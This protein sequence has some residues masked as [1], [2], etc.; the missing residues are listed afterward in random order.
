MPYESLARAIEERRRRTSKGDLK[1]KANYSRYKKGGPKGTR[2]LSKSAESMESSFKRTLM[3]LNGP[4]LSSYQKGKNGLAQAIEQAEREFGEEYASFTHIESSRNMNSDILTVWFKDNTFLMFEEHNLNSG[5]HYNFKILSAEDWSGDSNGKLAK[6]LAK[7]R[8]D[9]KKPR[10]PLKIERLKA[11]SLCSCEIPR[12]RHVGVHPTVCQYCRFIIEAES[13]SAEGGTIVVEGYHP[14]RVEPMGAVALFY[15]GDEA[16]WEFGNLN[17]RQ[18]H[19]AGTPGTIMN[20]TG[21]T[22]SDVDEVMIHRTGVPWTGEYVL[23]NYTRSGGKMVNNGQTKMYGVDADS[24]NAEYIP[25]RKDLARMG[26]ALNRKQKEDLF[27][28]MVW[29]RLDWGWDLEF[30]E[31]AP[32]YADNRNYTPIRTVVIDELFYN[33]FSNNEEM[34]NNFE[35]LL[36][37]GYFEHEYGEWD[38][39]IKNTINEHM[40]DN[41]IWDE[42][43]SEDY[44]YRESMYNRIKE[45]ESQEFNQFSAEEFHLTRPEKQLLVY[46]SK[47]NPENIKKWDHSREL[48][49]PKLAKNVLN[50]NHHAAV[51]RPLKALIDKGLIQSIMG[52]VQGNK[53]K[54]KVYYPTSKGIKLVEGLM[55]GAEEFNT[56]EI[57]AH[58]SNLTGLGHEEIHNSET[59]NARGKSHLTNDQVIEKSI[60]IMKN[61]TTWIWPQELTSRINATLPKRRQVTQVFVSRAIGKG[62]GG[63][64]PFYITHQGKIYYYGDQDRGEFIKGVI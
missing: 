34:Y 7:V 47:Y 41:Y 50:S 45:I 33:Q 42:L 39:T 51:V 58:E 35:L 46:L 43:Y 64:K 11:E 49:Q 28:D 15:I 59:F 40:I 5:A 6:S 21:I 63:Y 1:A 48:T 16:E 29:E 8:E 60:E 25:D 18:L 53:R 32:D 17:E 4:I 3:H 27:C 20:P 31:Y 36:N 14:K 52:H 57:E 2:D 13:F 38:R 10:K 55:Q 22:V 44:D 37:D 30:Y 23:F 19:P 56:N 9:A 61:L 26:V 54:V 24:F 12:P 62:S